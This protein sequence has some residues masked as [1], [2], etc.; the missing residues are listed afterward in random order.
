MDHEDEDTTKEDDGDS[1]INEENTTSDTTKS[2][3]KYSKSMENKKETMDR[4]IANSTGITHFGAD[5][6]DDAEEEKSNPIE[7]P[8]TPTLSSRKLTKVSSSSQKQTTNGNTLAVRS[9]PKSKIVSTKDFKTPTT[10]SRYR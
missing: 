5:D 8:K 6:E 7:P 2:N 3:Y 10:N 1:T 9:T 4:K